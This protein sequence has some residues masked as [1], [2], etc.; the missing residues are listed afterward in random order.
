MKLSF[1]TKH[2]K[3]DSFLELCNIAADYGFSGFEVY[4]VDKEKTGSDRRDHLRFCDFLDLFFD[5]TVSGHFF[6]NVHVHQIQ[7]GGSQI[8]QNT[9]VYQ[10]YSAFRIQDQNGNGI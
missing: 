7:Q 3:A 10:L 8:G 2:V 9:T 4:D 6:G 5:Q 1:S